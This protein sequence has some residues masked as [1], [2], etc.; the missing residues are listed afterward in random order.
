[1]YQKPTLIKLAMLLGLASNANVTGALVLGTGPGPDHARLN[2]TRPTAAGSSS[3]PLPPPVPVPTRSG[4]PPGLAQKR[5]TSSDHA[6]SGRPE[7]LKKNK[8]KRAAFDASRATLNEY[9]SHALEVA[10]ARM[11]NS[12]TCTAENLTVRKLW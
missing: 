8:N 10:K 12:T 1:M 2:V 9:A 7:D 3:V 4:S 5:R 6:L 11:A